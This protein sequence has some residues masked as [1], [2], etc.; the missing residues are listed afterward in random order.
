M[1]GSRAGVFTL[2]FSVDSE[3]VLKS[4]GD[5]DEGLRGY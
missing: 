4:F 3:E 1:T 5:V 2:I